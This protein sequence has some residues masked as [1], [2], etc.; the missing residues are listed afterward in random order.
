MYNVIKQEL[1]RREIS[2][3]F[4]DDAFSFEHPSLSWLV[5]CIIT[6]ENG[7]MRFI[8]DHELKL[9]EGVTQEKLC[10]IIN[11][12]NYDNDF[13]NLETDGSGLVVFKLNTF[14]PD[15]L[16][17]AKDAFSNAFEFFLKKT[18]HEFHKLHH[19]VHEISS[20]Q[21]ENESC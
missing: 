14:L 21:K 13:G 20:K 12:I 6:N 3:R 9:P 8:A 17:A 5:D 16:S 2:F 15:S 19:S 18:L 4:E 10:T 11:E 7:K 1:L